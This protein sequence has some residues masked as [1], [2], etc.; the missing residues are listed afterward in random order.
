MCEKKSWSFSFPFSCNEPEMRL[1][2]YENG[3]IAIGFEVLPDFMNYKSGI[4]HHTGLTGGFEPFEL[5]NH[6]VL[7]VGYGVD[8]ASGQWCA[9]YVMK[10]RIE[11]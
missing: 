6:A 3:P 7:V 10:M 4:Y 11:C 8:E 1:A 2:L 5:T 9:F